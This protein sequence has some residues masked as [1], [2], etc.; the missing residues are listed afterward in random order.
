MLD[1]TPSRTRETGMGAAELLMQRAVSPMA[2]P[3]LVQLGVWGL[4][5]RV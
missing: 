4:G 5:F 3:P 2:C 1:I